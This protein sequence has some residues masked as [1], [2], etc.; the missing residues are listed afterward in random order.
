MAGPSDQSEPTESSESQRKKSLWSRVFGRS[1]LS[2]FVG[3]G[4]FADRI[5]RLR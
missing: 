4:F 3:S 1:I 2:L 5:T